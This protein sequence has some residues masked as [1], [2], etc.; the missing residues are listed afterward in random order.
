V[1]DPAAAAGIVL[2]TIDGLG[3]HRSA[4]GAEA[5]DLRATLGLLLRALTAG[6]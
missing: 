5:I 2:A 3:V 6:G 4:A 1:P